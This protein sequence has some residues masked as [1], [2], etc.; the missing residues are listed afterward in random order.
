MSLASTLFQQILGDNV[1]QI[2]RPIDKKKVLFFNN[3]SMN[4]TISEGLWLYSQIVLIVLL[5]YSSR[6]SSNVNQLSPLL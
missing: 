6:D 2:T 5:C 1:V 4:I 3:K